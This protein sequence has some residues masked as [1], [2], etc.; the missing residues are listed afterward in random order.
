LPIEIDLIQTLLLLIAGF[1]SGFLNV[2]AGGGSALTLPLLI[3][4]GLDSATANGTNRVAIV[5]QSLSAIASFKSDKYSE[6]GKSM[7]LAAI[8]LP[9]GILGA[10]TALQMNDEVFNKVLGV[11]MIVIIVSMIIPTP[12]KGKGQEVP[13]NFW[14]FLAMFGV[15]L[16]GGFIQVGV[17]FMMMAIMQK[18]L[19]MELTRVNM[20]KV[21]IAFVFTTPAMIV[22]MISGHVNYLLGIVLAIG[23]AIGALVAAKISVRKGEKFIKIFLILSMII[24]AIKLFDFI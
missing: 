15:G 18:M 14:T 12:K 24:M 13:P 20:H 19:K 9:G 10:V 8:T 11:I 16:Y 7:K 6:F 3:F 22:F 4:L 2:T 5:V 1:A 17:G 21:F 23:N